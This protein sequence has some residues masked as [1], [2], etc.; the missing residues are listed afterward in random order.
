[1]LNEF[2]VK[3]IITDEEALG[4]WSEV[5]HPKKEGKELC[6]LMKLMDLH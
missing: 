5:I 2:E 4:Q 1:M 6:N 3:E